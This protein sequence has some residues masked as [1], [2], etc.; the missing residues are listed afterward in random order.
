MYFKQ[1][2]HDDT[3]CA[4]YFVASRQSREAA[5]VDPQRR[6]QPYLDLAEEREYRIVEVIDTHLHADHISGNRALAAATGA[7]L[8]LHEGA[9]VLFAFNPVA[10][11][12]EIR[13]GQIIIQ[14]IHTPGHRPE[15]ISLL[16]TNPLRSPEPSMLLSG[17]T[18][19]VGDVGRPDFGGAEGAL[20]QYASVQKLLSLPDYVEVFPAHFE[21]SC[22]KGMCGRPS[23]TVGFE[24]RFNPVLQLSR[25]DFLRS[26]GEVPAR[27]LNMTAILAT[28]QGQ[29]DYAWLAGLSAHAGDVP[30][31]QPEVA[32]AWL[33]EHDA[34]V[35][36]VREP[37]EYAEGHI[38]AA[39]SVPQAELALHLGEIPKQRDVLVACRSGGRSLASA[40][41]LKALGY[42]R[43]ANL[44]GGTM[45]WIE[46]GNP[47]DR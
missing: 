32:P 22:G 13:L 7:R 34:L 10:D 33:A 21:G 45:R 9:E 40:R 27:P 31:V 15:S 25:E 46:V 37:S 1:F 42:D 20:L 29:A 38:P 19:F 3:G 17:D 44:E 16:L 26:T 39:V 18:L 11:G 12:D 4:S 14:V 23:T 36:D 8:S 6:I 28:N 41:F 43:V 5:V 30:C 47:V 24:R 2:L 35:V